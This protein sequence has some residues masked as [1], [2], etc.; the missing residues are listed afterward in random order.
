MAA[1]L[2]V[3]FVTGFQVFLNYWFLIAGLLIITLAVPYDD[4]DD[5]D[6]PSETADKQ[7]ATI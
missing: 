4:P 2:S 5:S 6:R 1:V 3:V 7:A